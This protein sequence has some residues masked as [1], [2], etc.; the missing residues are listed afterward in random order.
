MRS[1]DGSVKFTDITGKSD[2]QDDD[3]THNWGKKWTI[4][5]DE[6]LIQGIETFGNHDWT[7][8]SELVG[9]RNRGK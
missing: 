9:T 5:E 8:V 3:R 4:E 7:K 2:A 1:V 6:K